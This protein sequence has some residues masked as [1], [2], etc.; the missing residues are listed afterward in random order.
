MNLNDIRKLSVFLIIGL[1]VGMSFFQMSSG[2]TNLNTLYNRVELWDSTT[3]PPYNDMDVV[4][5]TLHIHDD[6][7]L[8]VEFVAEN[9]TV[10]VHSGTY[11]A[12][13]TGLIID[14]SL[15][16]A[17]E[18]NE[19]TIVKSSSKA[20]FVFGIQSKGVT[21]KNFNITGSCSPHEPQST[22]AG[23]RI[24][25]KYNLHYPQI[26]I[27]N[28]IITKNMNGIFSE[29]ATTSSCSGISVLIC[30]NTIFNNM[31]DGVIT[32][33]VPS[34]ISN[35]TIY[36]HIESGIDIWGGHNCLIESNNI[37]NNNLDGI[38]I[39]MSKN[40]IV[41]NN[42]I[43]KN[44]R[45]GITFFDSKFSLM[46]PAQYSEDNIIENNIISSNTQ[47]GLY[48][49]HAKNNIVKYN[50]IENNGQV[51]LI[52]STYRNF[53]TYRKETHPSSKLNKINYNN[54]INN[55]R[56]GDNNIVDTWWD[57][58]N[59]YNYNH[60]SNYMDRY[61][62]ENYI[63]EAID[64]PTGC[65]RNSTWRQSYKIPFYFF[66]LRLNFLSKNED[67]HPY[68]R[69]NGWGPYVPETPELEPTSGAAITFVNT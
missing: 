62:K 34:Q 48:L 31:K 6:I 60:W 3:N 61:K 39:D 8:A 40:N 65:V 11:S 66:G 5:G 25:L 23:I 63:D 42:T 19:T 49:Y 57:S 54:F 36:N 32:H 9:G 52:I 33:G 10:S 37:Y 44:L 43:T 30:N 7:S 51:G 29:W 12:S 21:V 4:D 41:V 55:G 68:A 67:K 64:D 69:I 46:S 53:S 58:K 15:Q 24:S 50:T 38:W 18:N 16:L 59:S 35:N 27:S 20:P 2:Y 47:A 28:N 22:Q 1:I 26:I 13:K 45:N 14:K 17:G 56:R